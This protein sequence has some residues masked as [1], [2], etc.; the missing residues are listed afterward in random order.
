[1]VVHHHSRLSRDSLHLQ[2]NN[3]DLVAKEVHVNTKPCVEDRAKAGPSVAS[4]GQAASAESLQHQTQSL[5]N[6]L[7]RANPHKFGRIAETMES[8]AETPE[9]GHQTPVAAETEESDSAASAAG[10]HAALSVCSSQ[11]SVVDATPRDGA[12]PSAP[13]VDPTKMSSNEK[14]NFADMMVDALQTSSER[15]LFEKLREVFG[16]E[17]YWDSHVFLED[18]LE[19]LIT[20]SSNTEPGEVTAPSTSTSASQ[21]NIKKDKTTLKQKLGNYADVLKGIMQTMMDPSGNSL[22]VEELL[23]ED[24]YYDDEEGNEEDIEDDLNALG[25][26]VDSLATVLT[27]RGGEGFKLNWKQLMSGGLDSRNRDQRG[28][29]KNNFRSWDD[30][31]VLKCS[32]QALIPAFDPRPG[33]TNVNQTQDVELPAVVPDPTQTKPVIVVSL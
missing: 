33:R 31:L 16:T 8:G 29:N 30:E 22:E 7:A 28:G 12:T 19:H 25:V 1:M 9:P 21:K 3:A 26:P 15:S 13:Q 32:F 11:S 5:E 24:D 2:Q 10:S 14:V 27:G 18:S 6:L 23:D 20:S 4:T 17:G